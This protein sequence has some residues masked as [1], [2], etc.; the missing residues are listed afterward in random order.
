MKESGKII[1]SIEGI[2]MS[3]GGGIFF[4]VEELIFI[5]F[6]NNRNPYDY[7]FF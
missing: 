5:A 3:L 4:R 7:S 2:E 6:Y 1:Y